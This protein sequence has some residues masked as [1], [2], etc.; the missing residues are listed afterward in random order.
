MGGLTTLARRM[1]LFSDPVQVPPQLGALL[2]TP[3]KF[4][5]RTTSAVETRALVSGFTSAS[6]GFTILAIHICCVAGI[7]LGHDIIQLALSFPEWLFYGVDSDPEAISVTSHNL[8]S[9]GISNVFLALG[10]AFELLKPGLENRKRIL[11]AVGAVDQVDVRT[12]ASS[13]SWSLTATP[14][15]RKTPVGFMCLLQERTTNSKPGYLAGVGL[16]L[17]LCAPTR[18][19]R[20]L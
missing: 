8:R 16:V 10:D 6:K 12:K 9:L 3:D 11:I 2:K 14:C 17:W 7:G 13:A 15:G 4:V 18:V 5:A 1:R 20:H 19:T